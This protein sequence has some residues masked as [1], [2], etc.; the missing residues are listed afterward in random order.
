MIKNEPFQTLL[1][2][3]CQIFVAWNLSIHI[4]Y[5][6]SNAWFAKSPLPGGRNGRKIGRML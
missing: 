4:N 1:R 6:W 3:F 2:R 5:L